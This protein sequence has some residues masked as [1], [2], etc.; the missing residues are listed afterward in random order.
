MHTSTVLVHRPYHTVVSSTEK[1]YI[2]ILVKK[3]LN[4]QWTTNCYLYLFGLTRTQNVFDFTFLNVSHGSIHHLHVLHVFRNT[5]L[6]SKDDE[7]IFFTNNN[8]R[9]KVGKNV[10]LLRLN[11]NKLS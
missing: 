11:G 9:S 5:Y 3:W 1:L 8:N 7:I 4:G 6:N 10:S 2:E